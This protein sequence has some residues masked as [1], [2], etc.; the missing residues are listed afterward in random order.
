MRIVFLVHISR[1]RIPTSKPKLPQSAAQVTPKEVEQRKQSV[2]QVIQKHP[3]FFYF[4]LA[5][6]ITWILLIPYTLSAWGI[7]QG[8]WTVAFILHTFGPALA[9]IAVT[10]VIEG[11]TGLQ[12]LRNRVRQWRVGSLWLLFIFAVIPALLMLGV[13]VQPG[14][15]VGFVGVSALTVI[16]YPLYYFGVWFGG[17]PLGEEIGWRGFALPRM[18]PRYGPLW[19]TLLLGVLWA[20]WHLEDFLTPAQGG[21]PGTGW[22]TFLTTFPIF[23]TFVL[24][25]A[26][27]MTWIF[28][29]T[30]GSLFAAI[31]AHASVDTPQLALI[32][33]FPAVGN[34]SLIL[35]GAIGLG[36]VAVVILIQTRGRLG[37][38]GSTH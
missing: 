2:R 28:N 18:Q 25:L 29:H 36:V 26:I 1:V 10:G 31:S 12:G 32:P 35:G 20:C 23:L 11:K 16:R 38:L 9:A 8:D 15:L 17:G 37:Y 27:I 5:Y 3:L 14:A 33:L 19:S 34:T 4:L 13:I 7:I 6:A 22:L 21:G 30:R 24:A